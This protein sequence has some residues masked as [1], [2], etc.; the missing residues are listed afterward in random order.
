MITKSIFYFKI[1]QHNVKAG[2][3]PRLCMKKSQLT[4][5]MIDSKWSNFIGC[6]AWQRIVIGREKSRHCQTWL[7][8]RSSLNENLQRKQNW[9]TKCTNSWRKCWKNQVSSCHRSSPV[10]RTAW[11]LPWKLQEL[12]KYPWKTC[13]YGQRGGHLIRV[14]KERSVND[15]GDFCLLWLVILKSAWYSVGDT[16]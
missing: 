1:F 12:K 11:T 8:R 2:F 6:Y 16:F 10:S 9:T 5:S 4:W 13:G 7:E 14:L 15:G 3:L